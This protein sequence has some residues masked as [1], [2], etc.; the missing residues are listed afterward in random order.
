MSGFYTLCLLLAFVSPLSAQDICPA[1]FGKIGPEDFGQKIYSIDSA[2]TAVVVAEVGSSALIA[3]YNGWFSLEHKVYRRIHILNKNGFDMANVTIPLYFDESGKEKVLS[4]KASTYN[5]EEDGKTVSVTKLNTRQ[6]VFQDKVS[7]NRT[8]EK[9]T[10]P[11]V[12]E[13]SIIEYEYKLVSDFLF[14][15]QPWAFQGSYPRLWSEYNVSIPYFYYYTIIRHGYL[16]FDIEKAEKRS[17][18]FT[19]SNRTGSGPSKQSSFNAIVEDRRWVIK[20]AP[21]IKE[22]SYVASANNLISKVEFQ[23]AQTRSPLPEKKIMGTWQTTAGHLLEHDSFG[24]QLGKNRNLLDEAIK[25]A[26]G[27]YTTDTEKARNIY[28]W[29]QKNFK[30][31]KHSG[32]FT[33]QTLKETL[34]KKSGSVPEINLLLVALLRQ[35]GLK[36]DPVILSTRSNG[37]TFEYYPLLGYFNYVIAQVQD[38]AQSYYLDATVRGLGFNKLHYDC[39][40]GHARVV[41]PEAPPVYFYA[42]SLIEKKYTKITLQNDEDGGLSGMTSQI[43]SYFESLRLRES[44]LENP[45]KNLE[46]KIAASFG[47]EYEVSDLEITSLE[48]FDRDISMTYNLKLKKNGEAIIYF[49]PFFNESYKTNPF[50][51][52]ERNYPVEMLYAVNETFILEMEIPKGYEID[53]LPKP[54]KVKLNDQGDGIFEY[55]GVAQNG[56]LMVRYRLVLKRAT[57]SPEEYE[58]LRIFFSHVVNKQSEQVVFK[59]NQQ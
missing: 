35:A 16:K 3:N 58:N 24:A 10:L 17:V 59:K 29:V 36:A 39:Y 9:F 6:D 49:N 37:Y 23:L 14:N 12:K 51:S 32:V 13:G 4:L 30:C 45:E 2:A 34:Q 25:T 42:D 55:F 5:L 50:K 46:E 27:T 7:E 20:N 28:Y 53:D 26:S 56:K 48:E 38:G 47:D 22:E 43:P 54:V 21:S 19:V 57:Y 33:K 15:F 31:T 44:Y 1:R 52:A 40:N 18:L 41:S 8:H 11:N